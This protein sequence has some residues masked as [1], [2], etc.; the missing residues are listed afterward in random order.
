M[1]LDSR[2]GRV[3]VVARDRRHPLA[4]TV[5]GGVGA[6]KIDRVA[7]VVDAK[8]C[9]RKRAWGVRLERRVHRARG[10]ITD[11]ARGIESFFRMRLNRF[12]TVDYVVELVSLNDGNGVAEE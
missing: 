10:L 5:L 11:E 3:I 4:E 1:V 9:Q 2:D 6:G 12:E 7:T 8:P